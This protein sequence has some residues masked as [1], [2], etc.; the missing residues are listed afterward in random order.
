MK[1]SQVFKIIFKKSFF[2]LRSF[3]FQQ[4]KGW[5]ISLKTDG[6]S[7]HDRLCPKYICFQAYLKIVINVM[8]YIE[9]HAH[10]WAMDVYTGEWILGLPYDICS[11]ISICS[12]YATYALELF[13]CF[14]H[15]H[16]LTHTHLMNEIEFNWSKNATI[17]KV[18]GELVD[19]ADLFI[20]KI[21]TFN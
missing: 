14:I 20:Q 4:K 11:H 10:T 3:C 6:V 8:Q 5:I 17:P 12:L 16:T 9:S 18:I 21:N 19:M 15:T 13:N 1:F 7:L 2:C